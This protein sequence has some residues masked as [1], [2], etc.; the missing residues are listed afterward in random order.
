MVERLHTWV[1]NLDRAPDRLARARAQLDALGLP[2]TRLAA[3]DARALTPEQAAAL[4][5]PAYCRKHGMTPSLGELG[6]YL[7]HIEVMRAL[8]A[9]PHEFA[10]LLEDDVLLHESLPAVLEG[11][12][13]CSSRW[14]VVKLSAVHSGT[15][16]P[17]L[18]VAPGH[19]LAVML[20]RCTGSSAYV[21]NRK[22]A[23]AYIAGLLPMSL[24]YD[25]VFDQGWRFGLK[26]RLV[27]PTPCG[28]DEVIAST[29][30]AG[31]N[32]K[33]AK[34]RRLGAYA[35]RFGNELRR[36]R[37]GLTHLLLEKMGGRLLGGAAAS[38]A[39]AGDLGAQRGR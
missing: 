12:V 2:W 23:A 4:D 3:V 28:H 6:C 10:L 13:A 8:L 34:W 15:P 1:I 19:A 29:I 39:S 18:Q 11:L 24:P 36:A 25:H 5:E 26:Y 17:Y 32:R 35:Y 7:S 9:G 20:S 14:D 22:A 16:V 33:F 38:S 27:T 30:V 21:L 37:Y 31:P